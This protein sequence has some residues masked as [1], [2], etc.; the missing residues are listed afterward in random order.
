MV[1][2]Y[3]A[4]LCGFKNNILH[5]FA[6]IC[7]KY[8]FKVAKNP[9]NFDRHAGMPLRQ[10]PSEG[11]CYLQGVKR[12]GTTL[13]CRAERTFHQVSLLHLHPAIYRV[14]F[15]KPDGNRPSILN[16]CYLGQS[17]QVKDLQGLFASGLH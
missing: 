10:N 8:A 13:K 11:K 2:K 17:D 9:K 5:Y 14:P 4:L 3:N 12:R 15:G 16:R 1:N 6:E 7:K